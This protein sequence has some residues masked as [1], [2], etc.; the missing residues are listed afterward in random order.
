MIFHASGLP[1][2]PIMSLSGHMAKQ[3][4]LWQNL[5]PSLDSAIEKLRTPRGGLTYAPRL[6]RLDVNRSYVMATTGNGGSWNVSAEY[7]EMDGELTNFKK[8]VG[9]SGGTFKPIALGNAFYT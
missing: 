7:P 5:S 1:L 6:V 3:K 2:V 4:H 8:A 9:N